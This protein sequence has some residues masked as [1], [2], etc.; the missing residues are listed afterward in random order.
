MIS[1]HIIEH[2][3]LGYGLLNKSQKSD[4]TDSG[5]T[6]LHTHSGVNLASPPIRA[7]DA[8]TVDG[9]HADQLRGTNDHGS[10]TGL[11]DDDHLQYLR[12][13]GT[14]NVEGLQTFNSGVDAYSTSTFRGAIS[15]QGNMN[16][17][18]GRKVV[19]SDDGNSYLTYVSGIPGP[20]KVQL[21]V[22]G[23]IKYEW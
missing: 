1:N 10:L 5:E 23:D 3:V 13:D 22:N 17:S 7:A 15:I 14:R 12:T 9:Q 18:S 8:D 20:G 11:G 16:V 21:Y 2:E 4:L 6:T 19:L